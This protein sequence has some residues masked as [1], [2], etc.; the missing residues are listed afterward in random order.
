MTARVCVSI[1]P[2]TVAQALTLIEEAEAQDADLIE[3][4][5]DRLEGHNNRLDDIAQS[6]QLPKIATS[7]AIDCNSYFGGSERERQQL[8]LKAARSDFEYI[9][10]ELSIHGLKKKV[11]E[12]RS[13]GSEP[14]IS[15]HDCNGTPDLIH[16][17]RILKREIAAGAE[18]CK[19]VTTATSVEDNI[20]VLTFLKGSCRK[21]KIVCFS[22][23][24][25]GKPSRIL[26]P[27]FGA[28]FTIASIEK[29]RETAPGQMTIQEMKILY[30]TLDV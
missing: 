9:D 26:S 22:M 11:A 21:A 17:E 6:S 23:G 10:L 18:I 28:T 4:R 13:A 12:L 19:I 30:K 24:E 7:R 25:L 3:V 8:L 5:L 1:L 20:T 15:F 27:I 2:K 16:I 14:I 29:E